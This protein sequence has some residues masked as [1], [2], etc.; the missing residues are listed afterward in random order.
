VATKEKSQSSSLNYNWRN[1]IGDYSAICGVLAGFC[2]ALIGVVFAGSLASTILYAGVTYG[3]I[4]VLFLGITTVIFISSAELLL[5]AKSRDVFG[6]SS[7]YFDWLGTIYN[8]EKIAE[9]KTAATKELYRDYGFAKKFY[10]S[11]IFLLYFGLL[12]L[13]APYSLAI[14]VIVFLTGVGF[15]SWQFI[16][17]RKAH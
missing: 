4:S 13:I 7:E 15:E 16:K 6:C 9:I 17:E 11:A 8:P 14:A 12:F 1:T 5:Q 2:V 3:Q 10:N